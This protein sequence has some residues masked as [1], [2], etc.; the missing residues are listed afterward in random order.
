MS[1]TNDNILYEDN[2]L[3]EDLNPEEKSSK[4]F[5]NIGRVVAK[6]TTY[7]VSVIIDIQTELFPIKMKERLTIALAKSLNLTG[8]A[9]DGIYDQ[10]GQPSLLDKFDY[11]MHG[12]VFKCDAIDDNK[13]AVYISF[14]GL[15]MKLVGEQRH[16][17]S[18]EL[19][20][21]IYCLIRNESRTL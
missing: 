12:K 16:L 6:G 10:S 18:I 13:I 14:G 1:G 4:A 17:N 20:K 8:K 5:K 19:D 21:N 3:V 2:F 9:E 15:L 11:G 7:D